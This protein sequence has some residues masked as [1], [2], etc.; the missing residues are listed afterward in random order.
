MVQVILQGTKVYLGGGICQGKAN[1]W[2]LVDR[3]HPR[4]ALTLGVSTVTL[5]VL[6]VPGA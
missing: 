5:G 3:G 4:R 1:L 6:T 2:A